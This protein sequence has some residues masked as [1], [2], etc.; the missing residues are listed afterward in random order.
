[1]H[2]ELVAAGNVTAVFAGHIH[3]M[4]SDPKDGIEYVTLA[5]VGGAQDAKVPDAGWLHH[6]NIVTVRKGQVALAAVPVGE[7]KDV[8]EIT[9]ELADQC[10]RMVDRQPV[11]DGTL[12]FSADASVQSTITVR[13]ENPTTREADV[14]VALDSADSRWVPTPDHNHARV[15]PGASA[16]FRFSVQRPGDAADTYLRTLEAVVDADVLLPGHRY[17][18]PTRRVP[19]PLA[20]D[21]LPPPPVPASETALALDGDDAVLVPSAALA[22]PDGPFTLECWCNA[23]EFADRTGLVCKTQ[24]SDYG[25]FVNKGRPHFS[26]F[27]GSGYVSA[28]AKSPIATGTW[29]HI[30]GVYDGSEVRLY[31]DGDLVGSTKGSGVRKPNALPLILGADVDDNG[32]ATSFFH[33]KLDA[34]RLSTGARY[35]TDSFTPVRRPDAGPGVLLLANMDALLAGAPR[36]E[37]PRSQLPTVTGRPTLVP[38]N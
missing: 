2:K 3:H 31:V 24:S 14:T 18:L 29:H 10:A 26:V 34:V 8:R 27:L 13:V 7:V 1:V 9:G 35:T 19:V 17:S 25:I 23:D 11:I 12:V 22:L 21:S 16:E 28:S 15:A 33:G 38:A 4:R 20:L 37:S 30:A 36:L 32:R 6:F 5:T